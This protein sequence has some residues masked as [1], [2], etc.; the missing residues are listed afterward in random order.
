MKTSMTMRDYIE[1]APGV[2]RANLA[3]WNELTQSVADL[4]AVLPG[5]LPRDIWLIASGSSHNAACIAR[6][7]MESCLG[8]DVRLHVVTPFTFVHYDHDVHADDLALVISQSGFSTNALEALDALRAQGCPAVCVTGNAEADAADHADAVIDY[9]VGE[10]EVG[11][12]TKGVTTLALFLMLMAVRL[13]GKTDRLVELARALDAADVVRKSSYDFVDAHFKA[14]TSMSSCYCCA[15]GGTMGVAFEGALKI[16]E[17]VHVPSV[18]YEAEEYIHGP[19]LQLTPNHT[20]FFF[21]ANDGASARVAQ[22]YRATREVT[23][24][25]F[26]VTGNATFAKDGNALVL[27]PESVPTPDT[28]SLAYL[29]FVQLVS[30]LASDALGSTKQ[31]PLLKRFKAIAASKTEHWVNLD[32]DE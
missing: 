2:A 24:R 9:G 20:V 31:H 16:G 26:L 14:L 21:D 4:C 15:A 11:Y 29:P 28:V 23:D 8:S 25:G 12:V 1:E 32:G 5:S 7:F 6:P 18:A 17:T 19:N 30:F 3:R 27:P 10:E 22:I 13:S